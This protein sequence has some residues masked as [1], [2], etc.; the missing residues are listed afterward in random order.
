[1]ALTRLLALRLAEGALRRRSKQGRGGIVLN[2]H[3]QTGREMR[4]QVEAL[5]PY[6]EFVH[7]DDLSHRGGTQTRKPFCLI[8]FDD[9]KKTNLDAASYLERRGI[10]AVFYVVTGFMGR[11]EPLWFD[12]AIRLTRGLV[13]AARERLLDA[14]KSKPLDDIN[15][16][17]DLLEAQAGV[18][19]EI[20]EDPTV[21]TMSPDEIGGL[22]RRGFTIGAHSTM[23]AILPN[24]T[25]TVAKGDIA[26]SMTAVER[27]T[28]QLCPSFAFPN[29]NATEELARYAMSLGAQSVMT[30]VP[31]W[32]R[33][34]DAP[35]A[36]PRIQL[37]SHQTSNLIRLKVAAASTGWLLADPNG[38]GRRYVIGRG[39]PRLTLTAA[40]DGRE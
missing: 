35:W 1:M 13:P 26:T 27:V 14:L 38:S 7:H 18:R 17:L 3:V 20:G 6:F 5:A 30:T 4:T 36:L 19:P 33:P 25:P 39:L 29:G 15:R 8:T 12:R 40:S 21:R 22:H 9:G 24:E 32:C 16:H 28:G 37:H 11:D 10:P 2:N 23:H 34:T 31:C